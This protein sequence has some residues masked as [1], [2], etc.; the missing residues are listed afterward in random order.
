MRKLAEAGAP[1]PE[2][3]AKRKTAF[4]WSHDV[5]WD[6]DIQRQTRL[7]HTWRNR[8]S[9]SSMIKSTGAPVDFISEED[10]FS[11]YPF[12]LAPAYQLI[13]DKLIQKWEKYVQ[14][15]GHLILTCRT[16]QK[17]KNGHFFEGAIAEPI[18]KLIGAGHEFQD[19]LLSDMAGK[20]K[21]GDIVYEWNRWGEILTPHKG[22]EVLVTYADQ[23]YKGKAAATFRKLG[24]GSVTFIGVSTIDGQL[25]REIVR[26]VYK[27]AG[28]EIEDLPKG[29]YLEWRD[30]LYVGTNYTGEVYHM[31]IPENGKILVGKNP[32]KA[33]E[34]II[35]KEE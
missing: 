2:K 8:N 18:S 10:D 26:G 6:L 22:T 14:D 23:F 24:K 13:D 30:G 31:P 7:W 25:E 21:S 15:G 17:D 29:I 28:V 19:M 3:L 9:Y 33:A 5:M 32:I 4:L 16:G 1:L 35:W 20:V 34:V 27:K 11:A 12:M